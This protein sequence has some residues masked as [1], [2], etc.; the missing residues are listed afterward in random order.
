MSDTP[1]QEVPGSGWGAPSNPIPPAPVH[2]P[3]Y[4]SPQPYPPMVHTQYASTPPAY[5]HPSTDQRQNTGLIVAA[6]IIA[7]VTAFYM[8]PWAIA[9]TRGR[10]NQGAIG[11]V[12]FLLGWTFIG[13][14]V[15]L[16]MACQ[17]H[18]PVSHGGTTTVVLA[19]HFQTATFSAPAAGW[20][21][22]PDSPGRRYWDGA[23]WS[24]H[25]SP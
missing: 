20:F 4:V 7:F 13:W 3:T 21:P 24:D 8:L 10:S 22:S 23:R 14:I 11:L 19:Q 9:A 17:S 18:T 12:N 5:A 1:A 2:Q 25:R 16:V 15:A 6:W